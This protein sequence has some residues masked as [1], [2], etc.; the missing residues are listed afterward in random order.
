MGGAFLGRNKNSNRIGVIGYNKFG[1]EMTIEQY[2]GTGDV[3][4]RFV[5]TGNMTKTSWVAFRKGEVKNPYDKS[6]YSVGYLGEGS[7]KVNEN[8]TMTKHYQ[9]WNSMI[10][11]CYNKKYLNRFPTYKDCIVCE[12]WHNFQNFAKW[13]DENYYEIDS[14]VMCL[15]KDILI[16]GN[17]VYSPETCVFVPRKINMIFVKRNS[18]RGDFPIGVIYRKD[19]IK[20]PYESICG[21]GKGNRIH[22]GNFSTPEKDFNTYKTYKEKII[23]QIAEDYKGKIPTKLYIAM[24]K[25]EVEITD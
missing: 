8:G 12:E 19:I 17:K 7:Y 10:S 14:E 23:K 20:L 25:Y 16:K 5:K 9:T 11:R 24:L 1:S 3:L 4:V 21:D 2:K 15:D 18:E 6:V 13:Y 22:L